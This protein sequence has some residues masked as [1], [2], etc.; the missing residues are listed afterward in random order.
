MV[1]VSK[2]GYQ[3]RAKMRNLDTAQGNLRFQHCQLGNM[4]K[5]LHEDYVYPS[6]IRFNNEVN[7]SMVSIFWDAAK[8]LEDP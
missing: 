4:M 1:A 8:L 3:T 7:L 2:K 5:H 6:E